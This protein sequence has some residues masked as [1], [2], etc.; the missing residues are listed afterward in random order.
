MGGRI[1]L[2][3]GDA[4]RPDG[5][6]LFKSGVQPAR[7]LERR[8]VRVGIP[9]VILCPACFR[10]GLFQSVALD[11]ARQV[12]QQP[13]GIFG[14]KPRL[15]RL[16]RIASGPI[17]HGYPGG[18]IV[19]QTLGKNRPERECDGQ[20][21]QSEPEALHLEDLPNFAPR[22]QQHIIHVDRRAHQAAS[23]SIAV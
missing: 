12:A 1:R 13:L 8:D 23:L 6:D 7:T 9:A 20:D 14:R 5:S 22:D 21:Q 10:I 18:L 15:Q 3:L 4:L 11:V 2:E 16:R 17:H 19:I